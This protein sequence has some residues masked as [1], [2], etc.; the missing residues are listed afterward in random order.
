[1]SHCPNSSFFFFPTCQWLAPHTWILW[2]SQFDHNIIIIPKR[3]PTNID[4][5]ATSSD[6]CTPAW[7]TK[8]E[9]LEGVAEAIAPVTTVYKEPNTEVA[10][11]KP[12]VARVKPFPPSLVIIVTASPPTAIFFGLD[13]E[14]DNN[15]GRRLTCNCF[16]STFCGTSNIPKDTCS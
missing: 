6:V 10:T 5:R 11:P 4:P 2:S 8:A 9:L 13:T 1:M 12:E 3:V 15:N 14:L 7:G 16:K